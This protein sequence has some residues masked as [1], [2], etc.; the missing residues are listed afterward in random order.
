[1]NTPGFSTLVLRHRTYF[2]TRATAEQFDEW[3]RPQ[4]M[5]HPLGT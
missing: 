1:M 2:G 4:D 3:V 5:T